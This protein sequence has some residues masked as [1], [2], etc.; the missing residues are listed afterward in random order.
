M[1]F[2]CYT[3]SLVIYFK[4]MCI[5]VFLF[6]KTSY[7]CTINKSN[8]TSFFFFKATKNNTIM[9]QFNTIPSV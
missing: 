1:R 4:H 5:Y 9:I 6:S 3:T 2:L 7:D 8:Y